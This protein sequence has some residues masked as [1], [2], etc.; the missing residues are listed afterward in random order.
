MKL[1]VAYAFIGVIAAEFHPVGSGIGY[2][3]SYAYNNFDNRTMYALML[4]ILV[5][6]I[7]L[8]MVLHVWEQ[9]L[10]RRRGGP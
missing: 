5:V 9:R 10:Y 1:A 8:N 4:L 2:S 7:A 6:I 3:I